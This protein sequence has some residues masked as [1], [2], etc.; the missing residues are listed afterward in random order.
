MAQASVEAVAP[1]VDPIRQVRHQIDQSRRL[2][3][4]EFS[5]QRAFAFH[6]QVE[7]EESRTRLPKNSTG[8]LSR[9]N[10]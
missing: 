3:A 8:T 7:L 6:Q 9:W 10:S 2:I 1:R 5:K 4:E